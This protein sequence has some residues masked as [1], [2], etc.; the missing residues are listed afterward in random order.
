MQKTAEYKKFHEDCMNTVAQYVFPMKKYF[1]KDRNIQYE[2]FNQLVQDF[3]K[4]W[5]ESK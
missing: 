5:V 1:G 2:C 3:E 4:E